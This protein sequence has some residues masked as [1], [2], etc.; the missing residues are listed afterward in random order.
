MNNEYEPSEIKKQC[1]LALSFLALDNLTPNA[2][3]ARTE[4][5]LEALECAAKNLATDYGFIGAKAEACEL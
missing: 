2:D 1:G 4:S 3:E 5:F